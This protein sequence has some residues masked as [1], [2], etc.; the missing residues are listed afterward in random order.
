MAT[1]LQTLKGEFFSQTK[2]LQYK[3]GLQGQVVLDGII[4]VGNRAGPSLS[5]TYICHEV[6]HF[7]E[8]D[9]ARMDLYGWGLKVPEVWVYDRMC[10]E[11]TG[12]SITEREI[13]VAA[14]QAN[15]QE[16]LNGSVRV[17]SITDSFQYLPDHHF[18][19]LEDGSPAYMENDTRDISYREKN[20][21]RLRWIANRVQEL[22]SVYT[23]DRFVSEWHRK[24]ALLNFRNAVS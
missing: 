9:D 22:R 20:A 5:W 19:P 13:R 1:P 7:V 23:M 3:P 18:V 17:S 16:Y 12:M 2:K 4:Y 8:I 11:P 21:S 6:A 14:Y 15:L 24:T 10:C